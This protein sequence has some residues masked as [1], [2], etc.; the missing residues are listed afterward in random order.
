MSDFHG[1]FVWY[2]LMTSDLP[3]AEAFYRALVGWGIDGA[4]MDA[5]PYSLV[6]V[7]DAQ[8]A[9]MLEIPPVLQA[10][11]RQPSWSGYIGVDDVDAMSARVLQAGGKIHRP[12]TDIPDV[13]RFAVVADPQG[14]PFVL[15]APT[16]GD[17]P[18]RPAPGTTGTIGWHELAAM[19]WQGAFEF[20]ASLFGWTRGRA[21][22]MGEF[23]IYQLFEIGGVAVGGVM[24]KAPDQPAPGWLYYIQ[25]DAAGAAAQ[26]VRELGGSVTSGP[27]QVPGGSWVVQGVDPQG[28]RFALVSAVA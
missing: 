5:A 18:T 24:T 13:G 3:G 4:D 16:P 10:T 15:F 21:I 17:L 8:V 19:E 20:Y 6:Q 23:G 25:V 12:G 27:H 28:A 26:R 2:E 22:D 11:G 14:A 1:H 9:G 7:G